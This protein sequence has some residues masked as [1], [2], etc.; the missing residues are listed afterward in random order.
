MPV[1]VVGM[2]VG[3]E[4]KGM[5]SKLQAVTIVSRQFK[6]LTS[7]DATLTKCDHI[8]DNAESS[9][10]ERRALKMSASCAKRNRDRNGVADGEEDHTNTAEGV[11]GGNGTKI[12]APERNLNDHAEHHGVEWQPERDVDLLP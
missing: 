6:G 12:D 7:H 5:A 4:N 1:W 8:A 11:V 10:M 2:V 3:I 9:H